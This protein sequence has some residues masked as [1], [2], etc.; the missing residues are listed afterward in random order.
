VP[1]DIALAIL[2]QRSKIFARVIVD[3]GKVCSGGI[4]IVPASSQGT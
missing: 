3:H 2:E 1:L 4:S